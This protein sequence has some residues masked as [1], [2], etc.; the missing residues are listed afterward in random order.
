M[1]SAVVEQSLGPIFF[2]KSDKEKVEERVN[3]FLAFAFPQMLKHEGALRAALRLSLQQWA[4]ERSKISEQ[5]EKLV[6]GNRKEILYNLLLPLKG[7]LSQELYDKVI[8]SISII[9]GS[10]ILMVLK[11]IW[12]FDN[13]QVITLSQWI[14]KAIINQAKIDAQSERC[15]KVIKNS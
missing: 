2:W 3:D 7:E 6:R 8:Y 9:Y 1:V 12:N 14:A 10:E 15:D 4:T 5:S 13:E 11:D